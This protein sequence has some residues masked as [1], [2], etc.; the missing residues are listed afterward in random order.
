MMG[1]LRHG[2]GVLLMAVSIAVC[3]D[4][5]F[6]PT[7]PNDTVEDVFASIMK[8]WQQDDIDGLYSL[9]MVTDAAKKYVSE[10]EL[11][12]VITESMLPKE[13]KH[14]PCHIRKQDSRSVTPSPVEDTN[15]TE[16]SI[17]QIL[18]NGKILV[19]SEHGEPNITYIQYECVDNRH[20]VVAKY[21]MTLGKTQQGW[22]ILL[23]PSIGVW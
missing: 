10:A 1:V 16:I 8:A 18:V 12:Q 2:I 5:T 20:S 13:A 3:A 19:S 14:W 11:R 23:L 21:D 9:L 6:K 15:I 17:L 22:M 4:T 7:L